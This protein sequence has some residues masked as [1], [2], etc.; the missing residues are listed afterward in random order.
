MMKFKKL[1]AFLIVFLGFLMPSFAQ[2]EINTEVGSDRIAH[3]TAYIPNATTVELVGLGG[4]YGL[5]N[6]RVAFKDDGKGFWTASTPALESGFHYY[7]LYVNGIQTVNPNEK[8]LYYGI[9]LNKHFLQCYKKCI[10]P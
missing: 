6:L 3:L 1:V 4:S 9:K 2:Y 10:I 8:V 7:G 5:Y